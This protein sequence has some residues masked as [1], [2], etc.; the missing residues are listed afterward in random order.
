MAK[1]FKLKFWVGL[2]LIL[3]LLVTAGCSGYVSPQGNGGAAQ[4]T[5]MDAA[6]SAYFV[7]VTW[8][9]EHSDQVL[10]LDARGEAEYNK[11]HISGALNSPWQMFAN[12]NA[13]PGQPGWGTLLDQKELAT[14]LGALGIDGK[15]IIIVYADPK[16]WGEDGR[17]VWMLRM[18]GLQN[19]KMLDGGWKTW[20]AGKNAVT[21][22]VPV[23][24][25]TTLA[26]SSLDQEFNAT[27]EWILGNKSK[28]KIVDSRSRK[29]YDG[30]TDFGESR[31]GHLPQAALISF[32]DTFNS[33]GTV[34]STEDLKKLF[35]AAGLQPDN[36]IVTYCTAGIRSA[37][38]ALLLRM[39]GYDKARNYDASFYE[40]AGKSSLEVLK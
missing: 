6:K 31:G 17:I 23:V 30:A 18:A 19:S 20:A 38:M 25:A 10:I 8:L 16:G 2:G 3:M 36:E 37:H 33:D 27:T 24:H 7:D 12:M 29:E 28:I 39:A 14:K 9:K 13:Q 32:T 26:I 4:P 11:G 21:K 40:W 1:V 22:D 34:K 15:K 35:S 5:L